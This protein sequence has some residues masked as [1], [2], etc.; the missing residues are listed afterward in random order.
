MK[1]LKRYINFKIN[2]NDDYRIDHRAPDSEGDTPLYNLEDV[3]GDDIYGPNALRYFGTNS[4]YDSETIKIMQ[5]V[6]NKPEQKVTIYRAVPK[7]LTNGEKI[8]RY[9]DHLNYI[10]K[11]GEFPNGITNWQNINQYREFLETELNELKSL[12]DNPEIK[13][14]HRGDWISINKKYTIEHGKRNVNNDYDILSKVV[15]AKDIFTDGN[16]IHEYGY[17]PQD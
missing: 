4:P 5:N 7:V 16:S 15:K 13:N 3:Y 17:D 1:H 11:T 10:N 14:F 6:R 12:D 2:E 9:E 8:S